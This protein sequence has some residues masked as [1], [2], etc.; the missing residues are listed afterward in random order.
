M[1]LETPDP[2]IYAHAPK[3]TV[4]GGTTLCRVLADACPASMPASVKKAAKRLLE[5]AEAAQFAYTLRRKALGKTAPDDSRPVDRNADNSWGALR[6]RLQ[7]YAM[8]P[9][10]KYPDAQRAAEILYSLF[11]ESGL[12]FLTESY[13]EQYAFADTVIRRIDGENLAADIDRLAG[14]EFL[15]NVRA[16]HT[17]YGDMVKAVLQREEALTDDLND[18]VRAMGQ[19]IVDYA[20]KVVASIDRDKPTTIAAA[21]T[22]LRPIDAFREATQRRAN[23]QPPQAPPATS[24]GS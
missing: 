18:H 12:S 16:Q 6:S 5:V 10:D 11:G 22:A 7:A 13:P 17:A 20:L 1:A 15:E 9:R 24:N 3:M 8:L 2:S 4:E 14:K 21:R 19:E 23:S